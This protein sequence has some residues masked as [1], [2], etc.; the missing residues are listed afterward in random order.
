MSMQTYHDL[1]KMLCKELDEMTY[2]A[3][4]R[5]QN[6]ED[7]EIID[8]LTH[9]IKSVETVMAMN[10]SQQS[11]ESGFNMPFYPRNSFEGS[12]RSRLSGRSNA[13]RR[14]AMGRFS[15][16]SYESRESRDGG[17]SRG[18][19]MEDLNEL[20]MRAKDKETRMKFQRFIEDLEE[21]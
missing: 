20:M 17:Y 6:K 21:D 10:E 2:K 13:Q 16:E 11:G 15:G 3:N 7:L 18:G 5:I 9:S 19:M 12:N 14:D 8:L 1:K 4:G